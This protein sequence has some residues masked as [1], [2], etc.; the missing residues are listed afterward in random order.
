MPPLRGAPY[1]ERTL[2]IPTGGEAEEEGGVGG[3]RV[4]RKEGRTSEPEARFRTASSLS[5]CS[6]TVVPSF[7]LFLLFSFLL[8]SFFSR[9]DHHSEKRFFFPRLIFNNPLMMT[10]KHDLDRCGN[11]NG[12]NIYLCLI[13]LECHF[14]NF[15][16]VE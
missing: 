15:M 11:L 5:S 16:S 13:L 4:E 1:R 9:E 7:L 3:E 6:V 10:L 12:D 14:I 8:S 2:F